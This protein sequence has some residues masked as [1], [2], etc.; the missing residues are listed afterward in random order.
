MSVSRRR[1][2]REPL[3]QTADTTATEAIAA[4]DVPSSVEWLA[5]RATHDE[6][7]RRA[8]QLFEERGREPGHEWE[9]WFR[10]EREL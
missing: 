1:N 10:A 8:Y 5:A 9:D 4:G 3:N 7:A 2:N 6:I